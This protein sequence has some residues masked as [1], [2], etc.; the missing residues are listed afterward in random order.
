MIHSDT[1]SDNGFV[2]INQLNKQHQTLY[3]EHVS[4]TQE[5]DDMTR[6]RAALSLE[7]DT[8]QD[9]MEATIQAEKAATTALLHAKLEHS[10]AHKY[11]CNISDLLNHIYCF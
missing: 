4:L 3:T 1:G 9:K 5:L 11:S 2:A 10:I 6:Q 8:L 7:C